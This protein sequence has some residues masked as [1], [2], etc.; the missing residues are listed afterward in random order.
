M[1]LKLK[2][3]YIVHVCTHV[4]LLLA[5]ILINSAHEL[6]VQYSMYIHIY[7]PHKILGLWVVGR[8]GR[9]SGYPLPVLTVYLKK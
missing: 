5:R 6:T 1:E 7:I 8:K 9:G 2:Y 4:K 3:K